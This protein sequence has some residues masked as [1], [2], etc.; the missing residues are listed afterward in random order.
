MPEE[1]RARPADVRLLGESGE[2]QPGGGLRHHERVSSAVASEGAS[3]LRAGLRL[4]L[5]IV[6]A[7]P[8]VTTASSMILTSAFLL[9]FLGQGRWHP[10]TV[11]SPEPAVRA[12]DAS[13]GSGGP[14]AVDLYACPALLRPPGLVLVHGL[15][16]AGKD[17]ARLRDAARLLARAGWAVAVP[18]VTGLTALRLRPEDAG[19]VGAGVQALRAAGYERVAVLG[20]SLGAGPAL[21][22][23]A[24]PSVAP[25]VSAVLA[26][27]GYA[28][29]ME[30]LRYTLTGAYAY[31]GVTGRRLVDNRDP[32]AFD[33]L[34]GALPEHTRGLLE[35]LSPARVVSGLRAPLVLVHGR[36]DP[37][38]PF[39][40]SLRLAAAARAAGRPVRV[41]IVGA[42]AHVEAGRLA[43]LGD[44]ARLWAAFF[45][46]RR[47]AER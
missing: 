39:T 25:A 5:A 43:E 36:E 44:L 13:T 32:A 28:S 10:L 14:V 20:I 8:V 9:E 23:A 19:A 3:P 1:A 29:A 47:D 16:R 21:L 34:A 27:G 24:D 38:V 41:A 46:F 7:L 40:E 15:S 37:A 11:I 35:A 2:L 17:D 33:A 42:V 31:D 18:T 4:T 26:L 12:L 45:A 22:A 30:L 6:L